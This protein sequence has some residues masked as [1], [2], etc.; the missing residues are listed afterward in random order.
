MSELFVQDGSRITFPASDEQQ[1]DFR[2]YNMVG[3]TYRYLQEKPLY[4]FGY[5]LSWHG[6]I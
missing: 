1:P 4:P 6:S 3:R 2:D 5:G